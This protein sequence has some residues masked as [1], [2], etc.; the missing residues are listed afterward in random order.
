MAAGEEAG[1]VLRDA[2]Q[3]RQG[4][5]ADHHVQR[6]LHQQRAVPLAEPEHDGGELS[7]RPAV[8]PPS[9]AGEPGA[10]VRP[11]V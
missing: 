11:G 2:Q 10:A 4:L 8:Y 3:G 9:G 7:H 1:R 5:F 6:L